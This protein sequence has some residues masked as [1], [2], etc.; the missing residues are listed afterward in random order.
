MTLSVLRS[1]VKMKV[2]VVAVVAGSLLGVSAASAADDLRV[3]F[4]WKL[5]GEYAHMYLAQKEGIYAAHDLNVR[6]GEGA[7]SQAALGALIQGQ[8]DA[9][10]MP[11]IFALTAI[12][13]GMPVRLVALHHPRTPVVL[14][15][16]PDN[17]VTE[18][19]DMEGKS[20][21]HS[22]GE[23]GTSYLDTL[24]VVNNVDCSQVPRVLMNAQ[25]RV[26]AFLEGEVDMVSVYRTND[27]PIIRARTEIDFPI[28]DLAEHGLVAPGLSVVVSEQTLGERPDVIRR[29]LA[30]LSDAIAATKA[31]PAAAAQAMKDVWPEGPDLEIIEAQARAT[32]DAIPEHDGRTY[33]WIDETEIEAA[34]QLIATDE[35]FGE[36]QAPAVYYSNELFER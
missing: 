2:A 21:A 1:A 27:L 9:V 10:I 11:A 22:V 25:A 34:L 20:V 5:K 7:G 14:I 24:C 8:E 29:Y 28:L 33:G 3:R 16:H 23:T 4:S 31:D 19:K 12:Q 6:M 35:D 26:Q 15:S 30:A 32:M 36:P 17:P 18:P 13:K